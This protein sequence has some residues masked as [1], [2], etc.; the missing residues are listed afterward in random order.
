MG[1]LI[2]ALPQLCGRGATVLWTRHRREPDLTGT[3]RRWMEE[4][5]FAEVSFTAP[6]DAVYS[7]G[8]HRFLGEPRTLETGVRLFEFVR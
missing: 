5:G 3:I 7:V 8:R 2:D 1:A 6:D 4:A